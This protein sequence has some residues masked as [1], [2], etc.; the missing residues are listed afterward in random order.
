M[1]PVKITDLTRLILGIV[2]V[3]MIFIVFVTFFIC[4]IFVPNRLTGERFGDESIVEESLEERWKNRWNKLKA[5]RLN[6]YRK[7]F[8]PVRET[9][10]SKVSLKPKKIF[11][12]IASYRD[13]QCPDTLK[14]VAEQADHP[15]NLVIVICQ[16]NALHERDCLRWCTFDKKSKVCKESQVKME[17]LWDTD[18]RGPTYARWRIQQ[19]W[20]GEEYYLQI[21]SHTRMIPHWDTILINQLNGLP[22]KSIL[23]N[24]PLE[25]E[26]VDR[27]NRNDSE[28]ENWQMD[29]RRGGL[30]VDK[31]GNDGFFRIQSNYTDAIHSSPIP[32]SAWAAGFHFSKGDFVRE[33]PYDKYSP[34]LFFGEESDIAIRAFT[35]GWN[36]YAP[37]GNVCFHNYK[38]GHRRTF[39]ERPDQKGCELLSQ[40]RLYHRFG[41]IDKEDLPSDVAALILQDQIPLGTER[42]LED[43]E[44]FAHFDIKQE[45]KTGN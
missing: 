40:F 36:F 15:E 19:K 17:R 21:D 13:D 29:K 5:L 2:F 14:N 7:Y 6:Q 18:A 3:F 11:V 16:Q 33:V 35:N 32:A 1:E 9:D 44:R 4:L 45:R 12:S 27:K 8:Y 30:F 37:T 10:F 34:F 43:Y 39:W 20:D 22:P 24:Y 31:I 41:M 38:R 25:Y 42:T 23:T 28:K 26:I